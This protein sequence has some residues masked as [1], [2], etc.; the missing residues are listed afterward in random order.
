MSSARS[1]VLALAAT[2]LAVGVIKGQ[3]RQ[4]SDAQNSS[5]Q[6]PEKKPV[7][8]DA[9]RVS[10]DEAA[11]SA[12]KAEVNKPA[13]DKTKSPPQDA[14]IELHPAGPSLASPTGAAAVPKK[15]KKGPLKNVHGNVFG[16]TDPKNTGTRN[17]GAAVGASSKSG[18][19][20]VYV[21]T[22]SARTTPTH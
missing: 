5:T 19:T 4:S 11:R 12:A 20:S 6:K 8:V 10:T 21:E 3:D 2:L 13:A 9:V 15:S 14:V 18:N 1:C 17:T 7:L 22:D 16:S